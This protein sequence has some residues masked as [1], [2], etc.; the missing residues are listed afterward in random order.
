MNRLVPL[1]KNPEEF[2]V[3]KITK[4]PHKG[5]QLRLLGNEI[6]IGRHSDCDII[7]KSNKAC[8]RKHARIT[9]KNSLYFIESLKKENPVLVN[10]Q[11]VLNPRALK[12]GDVIVLGDVI[13]LFSENKPLPALTVQNS[14]PPQVYSEGESLQNKP[15]FTPKKKS[16]KIQLTLILALLIGGGLLLLSEEDKKTE[17]TKKIRTEKIVKEEMEALQKINEEEE[18]NIKQI[19]PERG[20]AQIAFIRGFR[21]YSKG[22]FQRAERHFEHCS[23]LNRKYE[24]CT[25]YARQ[26]RKQLEKLIQRKMILGKEYRKKSQYQSCIAAFKSVE[27]MVRDSSHLVFKEAREN[28][29]FCQ[30]KIRNRI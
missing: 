22:F 19:A 28:R 13:C 9:R 8:S 2:A 7:M 5:K 24:I 20:E 29:K 30:M 17:E 23:T 4:G 6:T 25:S 15:I 14:A 16:K 18:E 11:A 27:I 21:D 10:K 12:E 3:L 1:E 26:A